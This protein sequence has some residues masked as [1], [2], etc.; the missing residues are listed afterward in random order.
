MMTSLMTNRINLARTRG[1]AGALAAMLVSASAASGAVWN[2]I[3]GNA[4]RTC[5]TD[6]VGPISSTVLWETDSSNAEYTIFAEPPYIGDE[7]MVVTRVPSVG[8]ISGTALIEAHELL[9]GAKRWDLQLPIDPLHPGWGSRVLGFRDGQIYA[10]RCGNG[11]P[12]PASIYALDPVD[13][14]TLWVSEDLVHHGPVESVSYALNGDLI[15]NVRRDGEDFH[16]ISRINKDT[17]LTVWATPTIYPASNAGIPAVCASTDRVY[18]WSVV[19]GGWGITAFSLSTGVEL[20]DTG[21]ITSASGWAQQAG[22]MVGDD[23]TVYANRVGEALIAFEDTGTELTELWR[24]SMGTTI[25]GTNAIGP[26]G[27]VYTIDPAGHVIGIDPSTGT[28]I[29]QTPDQVPDIQ[30][31]P[32]DVNFVIDSD[33]KVF[34]SNGAT[35]GAPGVYGRVVCYSSDLQTTHWS[36]IVDN[37]GRG[38]PALGS[39]GILVVCDNGYRIRAYQSNISL[40]PADLNCD[41]DI[42]GT[43][44]PAFVK[45]VLDPSGYEQDHAACD[46]MSGDINGDGWVDE[47]DVPVFVQCL[48]ANGCE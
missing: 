22:P 47:F 7:L 1:L 12:M 3:G 38:A 25:F 46:P 37:I 36:D 9:T 31:V 10:S 42:D 35:S 30:S 34:V 23:G 2:A 40:L 29:Y 18:Q 14:S 15:A 24:V 6:I 17:G 5:Y 4:S 28:I 27:T 20:Y 8:D 19:V 48:L 13:G 33:G 11:V 44:I 45:A 39:G 26:D 41:G 43:D 21:A 32:L 16:R